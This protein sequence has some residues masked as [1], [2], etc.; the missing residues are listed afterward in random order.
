MKKHLLV[1][2]TLLAVS[3]SPLI[4]MAQSEPPS[5]PKCP[6]GRREERREER[7]ERRE[8]RREKRHERREERREDK[9]EEGC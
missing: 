8:E 1:Y 9:E 3:L 7:R 2:L 5:C 6:Q 4:A